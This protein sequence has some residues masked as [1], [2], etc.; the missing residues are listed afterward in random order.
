MP[1]YFPLPFALFPEEMSSWGDDY[2]SENDHAIIEF[3]ALDKH[4]GAPW[5]Y[6]AS[7][8]SD[9]EEREKQGRGKELLQMVG[10]AA[11]GNKSVTLP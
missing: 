10:A 3:Y 5:D 2:G 7:Y 6:R 9:L 1:F 4:G 11:G 8:A